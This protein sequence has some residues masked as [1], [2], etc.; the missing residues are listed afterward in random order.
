VQSLNNLGLH[1][2]LQARGAIE[3]ALREGEAYLLAKQL[4]RAH[5]SSQQ[6]TVDPKEDYDKL[7]PPTQTAT[8][9]N[10]SPLDTEVDRM[11]EMLEK[12]WRS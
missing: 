2:Q 8:S 1:H 10:K 5:L 12:L 4:H 7:R 9:T 3:D 6:V 11:T